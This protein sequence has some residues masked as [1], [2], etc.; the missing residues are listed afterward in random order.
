MIINI[1]KF[2]NFHD[3]DDQNILSGPNHIQIYIKKHT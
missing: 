2:V 3:H 1:I